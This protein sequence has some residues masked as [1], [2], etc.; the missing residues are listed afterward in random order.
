MQHCQDA[1]AQYCQIH[2]WTLSDAPLHAGLRT[3]CHGDAVLIN[4]DDENDAPFIG[5][6]HQVSAAVCMLLPTL[7]TSHGRLCLPRAS[8][9]FPATMRR[10]TLTFQIR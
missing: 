7:C 4:G 3:I 2:E 9:C 1:P 5:V 6:V 8:L 10:P